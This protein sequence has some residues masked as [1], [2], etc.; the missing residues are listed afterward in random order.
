MT[1]YVAARGGVGC[2]GIGAGRHAEGRA[3]AYAAGAC[4]E[5]GGW[6]TLL[7]GNT[8]AISWP[9]PSYELYWRELLPC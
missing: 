6:P 5:T 9:T 1:L 2:R 3:L 7:R 4:L 8:E